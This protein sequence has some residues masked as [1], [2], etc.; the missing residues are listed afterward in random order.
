MSEALFTAE[1]LSGLVFLTFVA[2]T[3]L[4]AIIAANARR[5]VRSVAGLAFC[6]I[7][8]SGL[9]YFLNSPFIAMMEMLIYVGAVCVAIIF[10]AMLAEA[11]MEE[12]PGKQLGNGAF[13]GFI[14]SSLVFLG[15]VSIGSG[16]NW[17]PVQIKENDGSVTEIGNALLTSYSMVFELISV[18][19]LIAI[20]GAL[21]LAR[22]GRSKSDA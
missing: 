2:I 21:V 17:V 1:G 4:G 14:A 20:I 15:V 6:F 16:T 9:F 12:R 5:L 11:R 3:V 10:A 13:F 22:T 7:G 19:L 18:V 8:V